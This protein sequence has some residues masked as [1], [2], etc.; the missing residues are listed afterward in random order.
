MHLRV[1]IATAI[2]VGMSALINLSCAEAE[3]SGVFK[4]NPRQIPENIQPSDLEEDEL[5]RHD[6]Y[7]IVP[8]DYVG[9]LGYT[10]FGMPGGDPG[11]A[12]ADPAVIR[13]SPLHVEID[14]IPNDLKLVGM[15]TLDGGLNT[16]VRQ[17]YESDDRQ[18][19]L[20]IARVRKFVDPIDIF[21]PDQ[22][23][24]DLTLEEFLDR[25][26]TSLV[27]TLDTIAGH[28]AIIFSPNEQF[29][30]PV[31]IAIVI[32]YQDGV[33]T[34]ITGYGLPVSLLR[35]VAEE[36]ATSADEDQRG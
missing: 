27:M 7:R 19:E 24:P 9:E 34:T 12:S 17:T 5:A 32:F 14:Q 1:P 31:R 25:G 13:T 18:K 22:P 10:D 20:E 23:Q 11:V 26:G 36:I 35:N 33:N 30:L 16:V 28:E 29:P 8:H 4:S 15:D 21:A 2:I 6:I 3:S